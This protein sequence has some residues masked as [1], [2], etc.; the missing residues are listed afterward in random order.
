MKNILNKAKK[1][2]IV[3][4]SLISL[5]F[6]LNP[7]Y[8]KEFIR[9]T[10]LP[11][12]LLQDR[13]N[14]TPGDRAFIS[15]NTKD[16]VI[17]GDIVTIASK[18]DRGLEYPLGRCAVVKVGAESSICEVIDSRKEITYGDALYIPKLAYREENLFPVIYSLLYNI[19]ESVPPHKKQTV[20]IHDI[21][22][23]TLNITRYS[24]KTKKE[25]EEVFS[26]KQNKILLREG[27]LSRDVRFFPIDSFEN[28]IFLKNFMERERIDVFITGLYSHEKDVIYLTFHKYDNRLSKEVLTF[29]IKPKDLRE[30]EDTKEIILPYKKAERLEPIKCRVSLIEKTD[31]IIKYSKEEIIRFETQGNMFRETE[32][33]TKE[34]NIIAPAE[35]LVTLNGEPL[36]FDKTGLFVTNLNRG[37]HKLSVSFKRGYYFNTKGALIFVSDKPVEKDMVLLVRKD[38]D[39]HI[40]IELTP[41]FD[42]NPIDVTVWKEH[43]EMGSQILPV[44]ETK[45]EKMIETYI[46]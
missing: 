39:I 15:F 16:G 46:D 2:F 35:V 13:I 30:W 7:L 27:L 32:L 8:A 1:I 41:E 4:S 43:T 10:I 18:E 44:K 6:I 23:K 31:S 17:K 3:T 33:K 12:G 40:K 11:S 26:Q 25:M 5:L 38:G 42:K 20:Y 36:S 24:L 37:S 21:F 45:T 9:G 14:F 28:L 19:A 22:D 29:Q 34:F